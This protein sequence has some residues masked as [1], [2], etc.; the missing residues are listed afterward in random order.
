MIPKLYAGV[1]GAAALLFAVWYVHDAGYEAGEREAN[2]V[3][4]EQQE[5]QRKA[6]EKQRI[7]YERTIER[8]RSASNDIERDRLEQEQERK[9][10]YETIE[11]EV[12]QYVEV[13][14]DRECIA[15]P[16]FMRIWRAANNGANTT[17]DPD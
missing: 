16:D 7:E 6:I 12:V 13:V 14:R 5:A 8:L 2:A 15:D 4:A 3:C 10:I 9:V 1:A 17:S 11:K